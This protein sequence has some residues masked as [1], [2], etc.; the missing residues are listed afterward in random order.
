[1]RGKI[2]LC[3][4]ID[5]TQTHDLTQ[6]LADWEAGAVVLVIDKQRIIR[7]V[8]IYGTTFGPRMEPPSFPTIGLQVVKREALDSLRKKRFRLEDFRMRRHS[9]AE[10][11]YEHHQ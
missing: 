10:I 7:L 9:M 4:S 2:L 3:C 6:W 1:L 11:G 8:T 5:L